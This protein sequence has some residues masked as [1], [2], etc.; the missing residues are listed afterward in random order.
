MKSV[1]LHSVIWTVPYIHC[2]ETS[3][4]SC[5]TCNVLLLHN[6][7]ISLHRCEQYTFRRSGHPGVRLIEYREQFQWLVFEC[8]P[9]RFRRSDGCQIKDIYQFAKILSVPKA[10]KLKYVLF[11]LQFNNSSFM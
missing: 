10:H 7:T 6:N 3:L 11:V 1:Y 5:G 9:L 4:H 2:K 8:F